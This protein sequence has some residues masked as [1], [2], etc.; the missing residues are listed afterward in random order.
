MSTGKKNGR[1]IRENRPAKSDEAQIAAGATTALDTPKAAKKKSTPK[2]GARKQQNGQEDELS[3]DDL[4]CLPRWLRWKPVWNKA[5]SKFNKAPVEPGTRRLLKEWQAER[6]WLTRPAGSTGEWGLVAG[7]GL[8]VVD[9]D[10]CR[11]PKSGDLDKWARDLITQL[12]TYAEVSPSET[13]VH[14]FMTIEAALALGPSAPSVVMGERDGLPSKLEVFHKS[15]FVT[16]TR[17]HLPETPAGLRERSWAWPQ[18]LNWMHERTRGTK[19]S[20]TPGEDWLDQALGHIPPD[21]YWDWLKVGMA[22]HHHREGDELGLERWDRWSR[23]SDKYVEGHC[24]EK[25]RGFGRGAWPVTLGTIW[26]LA[27]QHGWSPDRTTTRKRRGAR[28]EPDGGKLSTVRMSQVKRRQ[29]KWLWPGRIPLGTTTIFAGDPKCGKGLMVAD[30]VARI[31]TG[32][33]FPFSSHRIPRPLKAIW[34]QSEENLEVALGPRL[35]AAGAD[36]DRV[37]VVP[38]VDLPDSRQRGF[39]VTRDLAELEELLKAEEDIGLVILDPILQF[40]GDGLDNNQGNQ[41]RAR[42]GPLNELAG[43]Y[44][45]A[46][47]AISHTTKKRDGSFIGA[48]S[49]SLQYAAVARSVLLLDHEWTDEL[50][51]DD[52]PTGKKEKTGRRLL[53]GAGNWAGDGACKTLAFEI[54]EREVTTSDG[55]QTPVGRVNWVEELEVEAQEVYEAH[56]PGA[57]KR[58]KKI[59]VAKQ[60]IMEALR[61]PASTKAKPVYRDVL[62]TEIEEKANEAG[63]SSVTLGRAK[64]AL[65]VRSEPKEPRGPWWWL[66]P[67]SWPRKGAELPLSDESVS[68]D[69]PPY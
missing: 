61:D 31:T 11:D 62:A 18:L 56:Q 6:N 34:F 59:D 5:K 21:D 68:A 14:L 8:A 4:Y 15:Q 36:S 46:V 9:L 30:L 64:R 3:W 2:A 19:D 45:V 38:H 44:D 55:E 69:E 51:E 42:L 57:A 35:D 66:P 28:N 65:K 40:M 48:A 1:E 22:L 39:D 33:A 32:T 41:V 13:G 58:L 67:E 53:A 23:S 24:V 63:I 50:D 49:G 27:K 17:R 7:D 54:E 16:V 47:L 26:H 25:W 12:D 29:M 60:F 52:R 10:N 20:P 43:K 37:L